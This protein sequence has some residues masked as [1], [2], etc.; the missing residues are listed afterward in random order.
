MTS[1][2]ANAAPLDI[3]R[4][5]DESPPGLATRAVPLFTTYLILLTFIPSALVVKP[6]GGAGSPA[7][8]LAFALLGWY[9]LLW[10]HPRFSLHRGHQPIR[11]AAAA[12][13]C[14]FVAAYVSANRHTLDTTAQNGA[15]R[16]MICVAGWMAILLLAADGIEGW[17]QLR[18]LLRRVVAC[19]SAIAALGIAQFITGFNLATY[20]VIPGLSRQVAFEDLGTR[21]GLNRP[22]ATTAQPLEFAA[23]LALALPLA[24]HQARFA[25]PG[26]RLRRWLQVALIGVALPLTISRSAV[27]GLAVIALMLVP[28]WPKRDRRRAFAVALGAAAAMWAAVPSLV[29]LLYQLFATTGA[30]S[31]ST[32]RLDAY[33]SAAPFISAHPWLGQGFGTFLPQTYFFIDDQYLTSLVET[34]AL[35]L[36][37][38]LTMFGLGC[39]LARAARRSCTDEK[40]RDLLQCLAVSVVTVALSFFTFDALGFA[41]FSGMTFLLLGCIGAAWRL[42]RTGGVTARAG[43]PG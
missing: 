42:V 32:S 41:T 22:S 15:D 16:D 11:L 13:T 18:T 7:T 28:T 6:L 24:I 25:P 17:D 20:V 36:L 38:L 8:L 23:V 2:R 12:F 37:V 3:S 19:V 39:Y 29:P 1:G 30:E 9:V 34:G 21:D 10:V 35:G 40:T 14:I 4:A 5:I 43:R 26:A 31:S 33:S 27:L